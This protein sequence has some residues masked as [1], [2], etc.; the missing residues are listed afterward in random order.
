VVSS[1]RLNEHLNGVGSTTVYN[2]GKMSHREN[3]IVVEGVR[4]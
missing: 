1:F 2:N 3:Y 4:V